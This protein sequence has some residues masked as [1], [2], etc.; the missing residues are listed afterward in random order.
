MKTFVS[1]CTLLLPWPLRRLV[2]N[3]LLGYKIHRTARIGLSLICPE[4]LEMGEGAYIG[5]LSV[6]KGAGRLSLNDYS[7]IGNLNWITGF[8][9]H[10]KDFFRDQNDRQP[11]LYLDRHSAITNRH[12]IDCTNVIEIGEFSTF[13]GTR[14]QILTHSIDLYLSKQTSKP[15]RIG[16]YCFVGTGSI[17]LAGSEL[18]DYC[19]LGAGSLL[20][21]KYE[22]TYF[23]YA[24]NPARAIEPL[25]KDMGYFL[26][27]E[28]RVH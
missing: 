17:L 3:S 16:K 6:C 22:Q 28:G 24:G 20:N 5:N 19:I 4:I 10:K 21:K 13:A 14:S 26:R 9:R 15:V 25:S 12:Y 1:I 23:L 2:L 8:P 11:A 18:P 7:I 27:S